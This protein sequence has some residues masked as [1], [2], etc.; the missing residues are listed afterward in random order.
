MKTT[1]ALLFCAFTSQAFAAQEE[2]FLPHYGFDIGMTIEE[3]LRE[4]DDLGSVDVAERADVTFLTAETPT[5]E[6]GRSGS[7]RIDSNTPLPM[8]VTLGVI[9]GRVCHVVRHSWAG[10]PALY[11]I[12]N[13]IELFGPP[14][15]VSP[16]FEYGVARVEAVWTD[17]D[18]R[19]ALTVDIR[20]DPLS[21]MVEIYESSSPC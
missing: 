1:Y 12:D 21:A 15:R 20:P 4:L 17:P 3:A 19:R 6:A 13:R 11:L 14:Q 2:R 9:E 16:R 5:Y 8:Q 7:W 10:E 18:T